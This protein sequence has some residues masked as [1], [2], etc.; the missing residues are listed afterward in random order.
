MQSTVIGQEDVQTGSADLALRAAVACVDCG[1]PAPCSLACPHH[2]DVS[3]VMRW[4][5]REGCC[6]FSL[7]RWL[8]ALE[9][10][11]ERETLGDICEVYS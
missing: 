2:A 6:G 1:D 3:A 4:V 5:G 9:Q 7:Q 10:A 11:G 8:A